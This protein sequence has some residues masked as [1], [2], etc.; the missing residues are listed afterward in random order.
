MDDAELIISPDLNQAALVKV[1]ARI[2]RAMKV[3]AKRAGMEFQKQIAAGIRKGIAEGTAGGVFVPGKMPGAIPGGAP[4]P[5]PAP[6]RPARPP[7]AEEIHGAMMTRP[8]SPAAF[9]ARLRKEARD[10]QRAAEKEARES[11]RAAQERADFWTI[12]ATGRR[13]KGSIKGM[14]IFKAGGFGLGAAALLAPFAITGLSGLWGMMRSFDIR[15]NVNK[16]I[17][18]LIKNSTAQSRVNLSRSTGIDLGSII[19]L[20]RQGLAAGIKEGGL[21][22]LAGGIT[23]GVLTGDEFFAKYAGMG[24]KQAITTAF[25][26]LANLDENQRNL[27]LI[28]MGVDPTTL[29]DFGEFFT[30]LRARGTGKGGEVTL[31]DVLKQQKD[32]QA[33]AERDRAEAKNVERMRIQLAETTKEN[34]ARLAEALGKGS[35]FDQYIT[36]VNAQHN[37]L[38]DSLKNFKAASGIA[39]SLETL[40]QSL[41]ANALKNAGA[42]MEPLTKLVNNLNTIIGGSLDAAKKTYEVSE[43]AQ[44]FLLPGAPSLS[45]F[46]DLISL[47]EA[48]KAR[49]AVTMGESRGGQRPGGTSELTTTPAYGPGARY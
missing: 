16:A 48:W 13:V 17:E 5:R 10:E 20:E 41:D 40:V 4:V 38:M 6:T 43:T 45:F 33:K 22:G 39:N 29:G 26:T 37:L 8:E 28:Q 49:D 18:D 2:D 19:A 23:K 1:M 46:D 21:A 30:R 44:K 12:G 47:A 36:N 42:L 3:S 11:A 34:T 27:R 31:D 32:D 9:R 7:A 35:T 24:S 14:N 25:A 15:D